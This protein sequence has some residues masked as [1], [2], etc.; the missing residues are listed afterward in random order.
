M[1]IDAVLVPHCRNIICM[2][3]EKGTRVDDEI[4]EVGGPWHF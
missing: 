2:P 1:L 3:T 4:P